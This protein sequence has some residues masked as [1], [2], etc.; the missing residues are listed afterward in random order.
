MAVVSR[1]SFDSS[2]VPAQ[3][4]VNGKEGRRIGCVLADDAVRYLVCDLDH[5]EDDGVEI[6]HEEEDMEV[7]DDGESEGEEERV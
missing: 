4:T 7:D 5:G 3:V 1:R 2:W 6:D